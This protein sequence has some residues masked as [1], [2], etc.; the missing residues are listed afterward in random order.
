[1]PVERTPEGPF[2]EW[3]P[4][5]SVLSSKSS[6]HVKNSLA[7]NKAIC[8]FS[9]LLFLGISKHFITKIDTEAGRHKMDPK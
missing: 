9:K 7:M 6:F 3:L 2:I 1:V 8:L 5:R 4:V